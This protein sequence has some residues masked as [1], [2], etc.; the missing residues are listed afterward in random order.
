MWRAGIPRRSTAAR[1]HAPRSR[2]SRVP[3]RPARAAR[4]RRSGRR[5]TGRR[6][7]AVHAEHVRHEVVGEDREPVEV[8]K[9]ATPAEREVVR[10]DLGALPEADVVEEGHAGGEHRGEPLGGAAGLGH[11][12]DRPA[13][14]QEAAEVAQRLGVEAHQLVPGV[15]AEHGRDVLRRQGPQ[16]VARPPTGRAPEVGQRRGD[17]EVAGHARPLPERREPARPEVDRVEHQ[18][19]VRH[20][21]RRPLEEVPLG[22]EVRRRAGIEGGQPVERRSARGARSPRSRGPSR[23]PDPSVTPGQLPTLRPVPAALSLRVAREALRRHR[24]GRRG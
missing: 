20:L 4:Q 23:A 2:G 14:D 7:H 13:V 8:V 6:Q 16:F 21:L 5:A 3:R 15:L 1:R 18:H 11:H 10:G 22:V 24:R 17:G 9:S 19:E 12:V